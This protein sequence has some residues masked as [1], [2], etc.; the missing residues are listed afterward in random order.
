MQAVFRS[1]YLYLKPTSCVR[2]GLIFAPVAN[3]TA[4]SLSNIRFSTNSGNG[5]TAGLGGLNELA[6]V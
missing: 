2:F 6:K 5:K 1:G 3:I 4:R